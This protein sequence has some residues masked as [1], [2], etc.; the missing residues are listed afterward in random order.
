MCLNRPM[1]NVNG[2]IKMKVRDLFQ[3]LSK[4]DLDKEIEIGIFKRDLKGYVFRSGC[5]IHEEVGTGNYVILPNISDSVKL[6]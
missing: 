5:D 4:L 6:K 3:A 2:G 1:I